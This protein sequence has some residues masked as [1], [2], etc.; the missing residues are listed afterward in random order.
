M[1]AI[2]D[3]SI[4]GV[5]TRPGETAWMRMPC[6]PAIEGLLAGLCPCRDQFDRDRI[7]ADLA[8]EG[9]RASRMARSLAGDRLPSGPGA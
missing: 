2:L 1:S 7:E 4:I 3:P 5:S 6:S 8:D 9:D